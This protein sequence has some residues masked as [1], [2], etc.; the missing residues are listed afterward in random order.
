MAKLSRNF[1]AGK[2]NKSVDERLVPNGQYIDAV[3]VRLGSSESTEVGAVENSKGNTKL[4][5]LS[6][7]GVLLSNQAK[8]IGSVDDGANDTLYWFV[9]DPAFGSTSPSGKLDLIVSF[10]VVTSILSYLVISVSDG[11]TSSQTVLNFDDKHLITGVNV[12]DGLLFWTDDYNPPRFINILRNYEDPSG[13]PLVDGGGNA[14]ILKESLLVIKKPPA[15]APEIELTT[16][17]GGQENFLEERFISFAYRYEYQDDEYSAV[18]QFSDVA[19]QT[20]AFDFSTESFI[21]EGVVNLFN[22]AIITYNS[23][24]PLVTAID[25]LFKDSDGTIIKVIE[26]LKKSEL[27]LADNTEYTFDFRNSKIFTILPDS[28]LLRLYDN[29]PLLAKAQTIM[30]NR[31]MYGNYIENYNLVDKNDSPVRLEFE[32]ELLSE[33]IGFEDIEDVFTIG[34]YTF[35]GAISVPESRLFVNLGDV[36]LVENSILTIEASFVH[37]S[38]SGNTP[39]ET[40]GSVDVQFTYILPQAFSSVY[41]LATSVDFQ[42][43]VG[44]ASNIKPVF[45]VDPLIETSCD[46]NTF[47]DAINCAV[48]N[49]LDAAQPTNW[50]KYES[51]TSAAN[52]SISLIAFPSLDSIGFQLPAIRRVNNTTTPT[53]SAYEYFKWDSAEVSFQLVSNT[54]SLHSNRDYEIGMVYMDEFNRASTALVS[55][56][57]TEHVPCGFSEFKNF[58]RVSIPP[59]QKPPYWATKYRFAIKPSAETY[60]TIYAN[61]F[62]T[63]PATNDTYFLLEGENSRKVET[64]DRLIVKADTSGSLQ[65]CAYGTVL[66]KEAQE[67]DF[68]DPLP[69]DENG[70]EI[71][72]PAGTYMKIKAQDFS[73]S[74]GPDPFILPGKQEKTV[75]GNDNYPVLAYKGFAEPDDAGNYQNLTIP[76]GSRIQMTFEFERRGPQR[77]NNACERRKYNL[78]VSLVASDDYDDIIQWFNEDNIQSVLNTGIQEVGGTGP[79]VENVYIQTTINNTGVNNEYGITP[80]LGT[81]YYRWF[82]DLGPGSGNTGEIRFIMSGTRACGR[83]KKRR[84][85]IRATWQIFRA[86]STL[87]FETEPTDAQPDLWYEGAQTFDI[88]TGGC[89][90]VFQVDSSESNP[91]A[92]VYTLDG[93]QSQLVLQPGDSA[94]SWTDC[95]S[96]I[97]S[98][99]TPPDNPADVTITNTPYQNVHLGNVQDQDATNPAII[100]TSF[101]NCFAFGNGVES[102]KVRDSIV[103]KPLLL[104]NRV[105]TTSSEDYREADRFADITY[106]GIYNDESNVN[107]LNEFNLGLINFKKTEESFGPIEK[108]FARATDI[109]TL[110]EDKISYVLAGK[111]LLSDSVPGGAIASVP[112]VLGTQI[113]R[114]EEYGISFNPE[115]FAQYGFD[116][117]F[118]DQKRG[119]LIQLKGSAYSNEQ[120]TVISDA[121]MRSWFRDKFISSPN[122]Q[123]L[124]GYDPYMDEYVFSINDELLPIDV[125]CIDC[126]INQLLNFNGTTI[127]YCFN[128][129][130]LVGEVTITINVS[131]LTSGSLQAQVKYGTTLSI[132]NLVNGLNTITVIKNLVLT[133]TVSLTFDG[134]ASAVIDYTVSCVDAKALSIV[135]VCVTNNSDAGQFIHNQYRWVD[136]P[137][138]SPLHQEQIELLPSSN[139]PNVSQYST[140]AG[141]QGAGVIPADGAVVSIISN[142]IPPTDDFVFITPPMN[143]KYLRSSMLY[144]NTPASIQTLLNASTTLVLNS[145]GAP[146]TYLSDFIMPAGTSG[147]YLYLIYDYRSPVFAELCYSTTDSLDACCGCSEPDIFEATQ[148]RADGVVQTEVVQGVYTTGELVTINGCTYEIGSITPSAVTATVT[149]I[150]PSGTTCED[151]CQEYQLEETNGVDTDVDYIDC[152]GNSVTI[153]VLADDDLVICA[154]EI[155]ATP[156]I[157][158][159]LEDCECDPI[160]SFLLLN[161][162]VISASTGGVNQVTVNNSGIFNVNDLV[163]ISS[164]PNCTYQVLTETNIGP[165]N[166]TITGLSSATDCDEVCGFYQVVNVSSVNNFI[167]TDCNGIVINEEIKAGN[168]KNICAKDAAPQTGF[169]ITWGSCECPSLE[170]SKVILERCQ[171]NSQ[172]S[173]T[174]YIA[175]NASYNVNDIVKIDDEPN[176]KF[177]VTSFTEFGTVNTNIINTYPGEDCSDVC[178]EYTLTNTV[179]GSI[180]VDYIDCNGLAVKIEVISPVVENI[181][182]SSIGSFLGIDVDFV[183]CECNLVASNYSI[184]ECVTGEVRTVT[185][186]IAVSVGDK[187][188]LQSGDGCK[189]SITGTSANPATDDIVSKP[190]NQFCSCN[191]YTWENNTGS[192]LTLEY[193]DCTGTPVSQTLIPTE[194]WSACISQLITNDG[195]TVTNI[196]CTC[197]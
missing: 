60:E 6:Y 102:Y 94:A 169:T 26:K 77:G 165:A 139:S 50:T 22:T 120:L 161:R 114:L 158:I 69:T 126:G 78:D 138:I 113:A 111:N 119:A 45:N 74:V 130:E 46:G 63:D 65:R 181:C 8:C 183:S 110:Q 82:Q 55:P 18:S 83:T 125:L 186:S 112:E 16:T 194:V 15:K 98:P 35:G 33:D 70:K 159:T 5:N 140:V 56:L 67:R 23:G 172:T 49:I 171:A 121:G 84:S 115:S 80:E 170:P 129:G 143:F 179:G 86:E 142:K 192:N 27:G 109:L 53:Q 37:S 197:F 149:S 96:A 87:V 182:A 124:G 187:V 136:G 85:T 193:V 173:P 185:S 1:I 153:T 117:Y 24:G 106:S 147:D 58:I 177:K 128:V 95:G 151:I 156:G 123:K 39:T 57:N 40:S 13:S 163:T 180:S 152:N 44:I 36:D 132:V 175:N 34:E 66:D 167:Y 30:G 150:L 100:D 68:L 97:I 190:V 19:F 137:F 90:T 9:T 104:G 14:S 101:F 162:C 52:Q 47:T 75:R 146:N 122:N 135:Q 108:L 79:D 154:Q 107:K 88:A 7:G 178:N 160:A 174:I 134:T 196:V 61:I 59:Q 54:K 99:S 12:I 92:F 31:L 72:I 131:D 42:E 116:K 41:E 195:A 118:S 25:L 155:S 2:M 148:C 144:S 3:N 10:N 48:P 191:T 51:G 76:S 127:N 93:I 71:N 43:K 176:C 157:I 28:E 81:N 73:V 11:G 38:F 4:T 32:T 145:S 29:V 166:A 20:S 91:I 189:W 164:D 105:T 21:N 103:G 184:Q 62:F 141:V 188:E 133:D 64:G 17:P 168:F 89:K